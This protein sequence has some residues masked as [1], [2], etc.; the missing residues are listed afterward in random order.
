M[1]KKLRIL[2]FL[3]L[4]PYMALSYL[5]ACVIAFVILKLKYVSIIEFNSFFE[6]QFGSSNYAILC[7]GLIIYVIFI[8]LGM[9]PL[10][11][12]LKELGTNPIL[13]EETEQKYLLPHLKEVEESA[14][15]QYKG[16]PK[17]I[18]YYLTE[19]NEINAIA[20]G[21]NK[22]GITKG[23]YDALYC[24]DSNTQ[25]NKLDKECL[26]G[27]IAHELGHLS[28]KDYINTGIIQGGVILMNIIFKAINYLFYLLSYIPLV[29]I[30]AFFMKYICDSVLFVIDK[31]TDLM[32]KVSNRYNEYEADLFAHKIGYGSNLMYFLDY[33]YQMELEEWKE[34]NIFGKMMILL[35]FSTHPKTTKRINKLKALQENPYTP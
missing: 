30:A 32:Y 20:L 28:N 19:C 9:S 7:V 14:R 15:R 25:E 31:V 11:L 24:E 16:L 21:S 5:F 4:I 6:V 17:K 33:V 1:S 34:A 10:V 8:L 2:S 3:P 18:K 35:T 13:I 29:G 26:K 12:R 23:L 27:V 22:I